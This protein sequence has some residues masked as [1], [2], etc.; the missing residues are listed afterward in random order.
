MSIMDM[1]K[2]LGGAAAQQ[3]QQQQQQPVQTPQNNP[4]GVTP[5]P[6]QQPPQN[7]FQAPEGNKEV[8]PLDAFNELWKNDP[9]QNAEQFNP[10][11]LFQL[12]PAKINQALQQVDFTKSIAPDELQAVAAGG[13][14]AVAALANILNKASRET[15]GAATTATAKMI[16]AAMTK[17]QGSLDS[18]IKNQV[19]MQQV[20]SQLL[21]NNPALAHPA[22]APVVELMKQQFTQKFPN[23]TPQEI[24]NM[25]KQYVSDMAGAFAG[26]PTQTEDASTNKEP[27]W[28]A[29][30]FNS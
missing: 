2:N 10:S 12:D 21:D 13:E 23:A 16:E 3:Q 1:F 5:Q 26:K 9:N 11:N 29:F 22:V 17:A 20:S 8:S 27:D 7:G 18:T 30:F 25:A 14:A 28:N 19:K 6:G 15:M 24:A 4:A